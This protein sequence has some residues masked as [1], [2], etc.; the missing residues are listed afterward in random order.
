MLEGARNS[1]KFQVSSFKFQVS[2]FKN[3]KLIDGKLKGNTDTHNVG[4]INTADYQ[5]YED[6]G[7]RQ[8]EKSAGYG[9]QF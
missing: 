7:C 2:S 6:G 3:Q 1:F 4:S 8:V 9:N 5:R